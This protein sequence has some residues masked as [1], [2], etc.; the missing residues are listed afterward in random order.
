MPVKWSDE[1]SVPLI[2]KDNGALLDGIEQ[3]D[4]IIVLHAHAT[5]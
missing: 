2:N 4:D 1:H 5:L 3:A